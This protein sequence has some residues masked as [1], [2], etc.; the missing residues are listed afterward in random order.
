VIPCHR[1]AALVSILAL[2]VSCANQDDSHRGVETGADNA[3]VD[4]VFASWDQPGSPGCALGV[5]QDGDLVYSRGCGG[6]AMMPCTD[7]A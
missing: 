5:A 7:R 2:A 3:A 6:A 4:A 1:F